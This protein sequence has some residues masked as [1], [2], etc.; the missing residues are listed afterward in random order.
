MKGE[1]QC[2]PSVSF[3]SKKSRHVGEAGSDER[4]PY[5]M[6]GM[7]LKRLFRSIT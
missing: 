7:E 1:E 4:S 3:V 6:N 2:D 5:H